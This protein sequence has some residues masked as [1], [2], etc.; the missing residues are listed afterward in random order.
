MEN[1]KVNEKK[2]NITKSTA[3]VDFLRQVLTLTTLMIGHANYIKFSSD[4]I[5]CGTCRFKHAR[6]NNNFSCAYFGTYLENISESMCT[7]CKGCL[8]LFGY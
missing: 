4:N 7:R 2:S 1:K 8:D 5:L 6:E 3:G